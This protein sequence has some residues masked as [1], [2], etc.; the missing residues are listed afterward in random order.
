MKGGSPKP[1]KP[2]P[3]PTPITSAERA[4]Q[5]YRDSQQ[6]RRVGFAETI[7]GGR[8]QSGGN[9]ILGG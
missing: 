9:S 8:P 7:L 2:I 1:P 3:P 5:E 4:S 6:R